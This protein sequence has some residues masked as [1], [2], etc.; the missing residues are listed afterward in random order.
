MNQRWVYGIG[1]AVLGTPVLVGITLGPVWSQTEPLIESETPMDEV[2][3]AYSIRVTSTL[4]GDPVADEQ[5]TLREALKLANG[6]LPLDALSPAEQALVQPL[7]DGA[8]SEI[9]FDLP[10]GDTTIELM[11]LLPEVVVPG[12]VIDGTTQAGYDAEAMIDPRFPPAPVV[13]LTVAPGQEVARGLSIAADGVVVRGLSIYGFRTTDRATQTTPPSDIFI[14]ALAP[15]VDASPLTPP[16]P[17]F[18]LSREDTVPQGVVIEQNWLGLPP[19]DEFPEVPSAFGVTVFNSTD[20]VIRNNRIEHHDGSAII[21]GFQADGLQISENAIVGN[22]LAGMPDAI[23][24]EGAIA[25][26]AITDNLICGNDGSGIYLFKPAGATQITGNTIQYNGRRFFR[27]AVYVMGSDHQINDN[28]IGYQPGPG[29]VVA[30]HP[31]SDRNLIRQNRFAQLDGLSIDLVTQG[32]AGV[33]D[34]QR[35]DGPNPPRNSY[36]RRRETG[37]GAINAPKFDSY[38]FTGT[39][40]TVTVTGS[41]DPGSEVDLYLVVE[42]DRPYGPLAELITTVAAGDDGR[43]SADLEVPL[44]SH[45][46]AIASDP[47]YGTSEPAPVVAVLDADGSLPVLPPPAVEIPSCA[48][49]EPPEIVV[50]PEPEPL[51]LEVPRNIHFALDRSDI[52]AESAEILDQIAEVMLEFPFLTL[53]LHGHT[54]PRASAAYN[55][56]LSERRANAARNYLIAQGV[57]PERMQIVPFGLTQ[58]L[59][60]ESSRLAYARDRRVEFVFTDLRGVDII[61]VDQEDDLQLE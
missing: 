19:S 52:S 38:T 35:G 6:T 54:D 28:F 40:D 20:A 37:N 1:A 21:S 27:S 15:P 2:I 57:P 60:D 12:L 13:T 39:G 25:G 18:R 48:P 17:M 5:L 30:A 34:F 26:S 36:H 58:R 9:T 11:D 14:S 8:G 16:L 31:D 32:N 61:F 43:F 53:E 4:D 33:Q 59:S 49:P 55:L 44:G 46:S 29:V 10:D 51:V 7:T 47:S 23:R 50:D 42:D 41:A 24:L 22:G 45:L 56:A 3:P